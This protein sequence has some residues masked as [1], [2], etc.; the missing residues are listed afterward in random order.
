MKSQ[1][2]FQSEIVT[3]DAVDKS[4]V[5]SSPPCLS[6]PILKVEGW[7]FKGLWAAVL[8]CASV[9]KASQPGSSASLQEVPGR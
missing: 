6:F 3:L 7:G 4:L 5:I 2:D 8:P 9:A 1:D